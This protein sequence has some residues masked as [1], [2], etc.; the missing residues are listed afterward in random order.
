M[1]KKMTLKEIR[2]ARGVKQAAVADHLGV[3]RQTYATYEDNPRDMTIGQ[4]QAVCA[5]LHCKLDD[6]FLSQEVS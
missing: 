5:F 6:I 3:V 4:A 2:E 1:R